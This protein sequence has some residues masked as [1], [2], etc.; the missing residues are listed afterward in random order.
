M[1]EPTVSGVRSEILNGISQGRHPLSVT[2]EQ[3]LGKRI[4]RRKH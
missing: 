2:G 3:T 4:D 1:D